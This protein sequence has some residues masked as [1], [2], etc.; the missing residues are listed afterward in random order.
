MVLQSRKCNMITF[1]VT[2]FSLKPN[3]VFLYS[4][5]V[6]I[7]QT[8]LSGNTALH[9]AVAKDRVSTA[10][11]LCEKGADIYQKNKKGST[12]LD[13]GLEFGSFTSE[14]KLRY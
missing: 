1:I 14:R 10:M 6:T 12:P 5:G 4:G 13:I 11:F 8:T 9:A 7:A 3:V 2:Y